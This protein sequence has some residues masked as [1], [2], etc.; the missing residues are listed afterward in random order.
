MDMPVQLLH[1]NDLQ[2]IKYSASNG[3]S[4]QMKQEEVSFFNTPVA[5]LPLRNVSKIYILKTITHNE[6]C[7]DYN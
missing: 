4:Y 3:L 2:S 1:S 5:G 6:N 7:I